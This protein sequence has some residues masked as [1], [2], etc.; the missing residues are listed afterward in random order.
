MLSSTFDWQFVFTIRHAVLAAAVMALALMV[1][2]IR[3]SFGAVDSGLEAAARTLGANK[4]RV[5]AT[6]TMPLMPL[7]PPGL[8]SGEV[9]K[10]AAS[11]G[12]FGATLTFVSN[13]PG[14]TQ[15]LP[16][17]TYSA[18]QQPAVPKPPRV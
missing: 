10:F 18:L 9:L 5:F 16:L 8:L 6:V 17:A 13:V 4:A 14:E 15:T 12:E 1:R 2:A 3:Q 7:M 11:L